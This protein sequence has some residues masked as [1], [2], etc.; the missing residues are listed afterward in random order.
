[1][2]L[3]VYLT[4]RQDPEAAI[5]LSLVLLAVAVLVLATLRER[6]TSGVRG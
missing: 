1:M 6:W 5:A 4:F 2:P 3:Q